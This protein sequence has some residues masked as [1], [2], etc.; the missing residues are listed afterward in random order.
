VLPSMLRQRA[1]LIINVASAASFCTGPMMSAYNASKAAVVALSETLMQEYGP[2]GVRTLVAM[3]G[4][5]RTNLLSHARGPRP[6]LEGARR[7]MDSS[8]LEA[9]QVAREL[10]AA[11]AGSATHWVYPPAY[12]T[13]WRLKRLMPSRF[14]QLMLARLQRRG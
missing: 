4:F 9:D 12:R 2:R 11:A 8:Q 3:P 14:Q 10:L 13:L 5:F 6:T 1:G 7:I